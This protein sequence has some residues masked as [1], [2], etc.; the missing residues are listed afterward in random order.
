MRKIPLIFFF[1]VLLTSQGTL[2]FASPFHA[3]PDDNKIP[4]NVLL[5]TIDTLRADRVSC[6]SSQFLKTPHIDSLSTSGTVFMNAF[7]NT[8]TTL[9]SHTNILLG[10]SPLVHGVHE[11]QNF[12]VHESFLTLAEHLKASGYTTG[13]F[14]GAYPL[15]KRFGLA[16]G[17]DI[18]DD[19]FG[20]RSSTNKQNLERRAAEVIASASRWIKTQNSP[21]FL[22]IHIYDPHDPYTPPSPYAEHYANSPYDGEVAYVDEVLG[23]FLKEMQQGNKLEHTLVVFTGDHGESLWE[24][25]E[26]THGF[27][28]YNSS[29]WI[30]LIIAA[31][32]LKARK[33]ETLVSH[34]DLFPTVCDILDLET[35]RF[36]Q[37]QSLLPI[38]RG[39]RLRHKDIYFESLSPHYGMGWA[40]LQGFISEKFK[41]IQSPIP[42]LYNLEEDFDEKRNLAQNRDVG[43]YRKHLS[44]IIERD[45]SPEASRSETRLDRESLEKLST[46]GYVGGAIFTE[47]KKEY[48]PEDDV[49][50]LLPLFNR[51][52][53]A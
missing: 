9:P 8:S 28:A 44:E 34:L 18:Y 20:R 13:A 38:T 46:L 40:P 45:S 49:K 1:S 2:L 15:D 23:Q 19:N 22:W 3:D 53:R 21:W 12:V 36:L 33:S 25:G 7:A 14:V 29:I 41:F 27:F 30:P 17:F 48:G 47:K 10:V 11:N 39:R 24:H 4:L 37:G 5:I 42:E 6:Y 26:E 35:P 50:T 31:P 32:G 51:A 43:E 16:Q 52:N